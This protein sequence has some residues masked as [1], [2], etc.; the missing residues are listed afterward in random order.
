MLHGCRS[1]F[2]IFLNRHGSMG[3]SCRFV[4]ITSRPCQEAGYL[5]G[6]SNLDAALL[7]ADQTPYTSLVSVEGVPGTTPENP[8][9]LRKRRKGR[10]KP[11]RDKRRKTWSTGITAEERKD[12][13]RANGLATVMRRPL[14]TTLDFHPVHLDAYPEGELDDFFRGLRTR[15]STWCGRKGIGSYWVWTRENYAAWRREHLHMVMHL[16]PQ[17]RAEAAGAYICRIYPGGADLVQIGERTSRQCPDTG[18][19]ID[20]LDYRMKQ[21]RGDAVGPPG[22]TR[23]YR[24]TK[25]RHDGAAVAPVLGKRCGVSDSLSVRAEERWLAS[26]KA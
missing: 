25:S 16:P 13:R 26:K 17:L 9:P 23:L 10:S 19:R 4:S 3:Q 22:P 6:I 11:K 20:G 2:N 1:T 21:L 18:R 5:S 8:E 7:N 15:I 12:V 24:E 14:R